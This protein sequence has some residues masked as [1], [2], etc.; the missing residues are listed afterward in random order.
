M[1]TIKCNEIPVRVEG[2]R[3]RI[4]F[5]R[6]VKRKNRHTDQHPLF[7]MNSI[8]TDIFIASTVQ[9]VNFNHIIQLYVAI[10]CVSILGTKKSMFKFDN[11]V[12]HKLDQNLLNKLC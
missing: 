6:V 7:N 4:I 11:Y 5:F 2:L 8:I 3:I 9:S 10:F 12:V 1:Y